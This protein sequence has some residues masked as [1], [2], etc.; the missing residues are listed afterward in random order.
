MSRVDGDIPP[1][2]DP[3]RGR[4]FVGAEG[5]QPLE[6][7]DVA[8]QGQ[9]TRGALE[10]AQ[11]LERVDSEVRVRAD[12]DADAPCAD[13]VDRREAVA[14]IRLG[15]RTDAQAGARVVQ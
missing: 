5:E 9:P 4:T 7:D 3:Q 13:P 1:V 6:R 14:E 2:L 10:L 15:R 8:P 12:A 11:L